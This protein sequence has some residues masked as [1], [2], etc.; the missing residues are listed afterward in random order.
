MVSG[1]VLI[2]SDCTMRFGF[3][4]TAPAEF[5][6]KGLGSTPPRIRRVAGVSPL[7]VWGLQPVG[8]WAMPIEMAPPATPT[9]VVVVVEVLAAPQPAAIKDSPT[10]P[11]STRRR[12]PGRSPRAVT[13]A[14]GPA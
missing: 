11:P 13:A 9:K 12:N 7:T 1:L 3:G 2:S 10:Q 14:A 8:L 4:V 5:T 6:V